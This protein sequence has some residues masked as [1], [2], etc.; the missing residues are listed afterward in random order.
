MRTTVLHWLARSLVAA[1]AAATACADDTPLVPEASPAL[2]AVELGSCTNL[3]PDAGSKLTYHAYATGTQ[4]YRW[5]GAAWVFVEPSAVLYADAGEHGVVGT[6]Y[7][8]PT[9]ESNSGSRVVGTVLERCT[10]DPDAIPWLKLGAVSAEGPG[11][12]DRTTFIQRVN[13]VGGKAPA[14]AG[15]LPGEIARVPY[16]AEYFF[17]RAP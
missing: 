3:R 8:G 4:V 11:I 5:D 1:A 7:A 2:R 13:T 16:T 6:H 14:A 12:F 15:S 10:P 17:Y 9:W